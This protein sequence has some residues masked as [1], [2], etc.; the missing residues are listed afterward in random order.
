MDFSVLIFIIIVLV[1]FNIFM[2]IVFFKKFKDNFSSDKEI[3]KIKSSLEEIL[4]EIMRKTDDC[5]SLIDTHSGEFK[6]LCSEID[7][8]LD[9]YK[10]SLE[11]LNSKQQENVN[12]LR[13]ESS[14][15]DISATERLLS[16][17][18]QEIRSDFVIEKGI[19][20]SLKKIQSNL[21]ED[22]ESPLSQKEEIIEL[23]KMGVT[24]SLIAARLD[25]SI[26][27][28][29]LIINLEK[30]KGKSL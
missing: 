13:S 9:E 19:E 20:T 24:A 23:Y 6:S 8:K 2:W 25:L 29:E 26:G 18:Q 5:I 17:Y 11:L 21:I 4:S 15:M 7:S 12:E 27:E 30:N 1:L 28:V 14:K 16:K 22:K 10:V 3:A